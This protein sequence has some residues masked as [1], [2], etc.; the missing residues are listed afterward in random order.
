MLPTCSGGVAV[1]S[2]ALWQVNNAGFQTAIVALGTKGKEVEA[3]LTRYV[4][5]ECAVFQGLNLR[6]LDLGRGFRGG[7]AAAISSSAGV[8][9]EEIDRIGDLKSFVVVVRLSS[10]SLSSLPPSGS[11]N[12][13]SSLWLLWSSCCVRVNATFS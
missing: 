7:R 2:H 12:F 10:L 1:V 5:S 3:E 8:L 4:A 6:F 9:R 11:L 13:V